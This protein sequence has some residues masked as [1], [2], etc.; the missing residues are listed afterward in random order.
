MTSKNTSQKNKFGTRIS[1]ADFNA[2]D[3]HWSKVIADKIL[4]IFPGEDMYTCAAGIS[5]SGVVHFG[6]F[7]DVMTVHAVI[8]ELEARG[9]K[10]KF[11]FSWDDFDRLRKVPAGVDASF[12]KYIGMPLSSIPDPLSEYPSYARRFEVEF[13]NAM[14]DLGIDLEFRVQTDEYK[15]GVYDDLII[16]AMQNRLEIADILLS[17][18]TE[19][20]KESKDLD[21]AKYRENFYPVSVYS[22]FSGKDNTKILNYDGKSTITYKCFDTGNEETIDFT[23]DHIVKLS[24]KV[25]WPMRWLF[26]GVVFEPGGKDHASPGG[27]YDTSSVIAKKIFDREAPIFVGYEFVGIRGLGAKMSGSKGNAISPAELLKIYEPELLKWLYLRRLPNQAFELAFDTEIY[28]QYDEYDREFKGNRIPFKQAV[29]F[30]QIMQWD[31]NK[32]IQFLKS[33][34]LNYDESSISIRMQKARAW[35]ETYNPSEMIVLRSDINKD[36]VATMSPESIAN[37]QKFVAK[38]K[39]GVTTTEE[40]EKVMYDIPKDTV[41]TDKENAPRQRAFFKDIYNLLISVDTGPRLSTFLW[42]LDRKKVLELLNM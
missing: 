32:L 5:P 33:V 25:D 42:A 28:R 11:I 38:L 8:K 12:E 35:L 15:K 17:F 30:G 14:K 10:T 6:N 21:E 1:S 3:A 36:Y 20:G 41:L 4:E 39:E 7:R 22:K 34:D 24:W 13:E 26:E 29:A 27:S 23:Q 16:K 40:L 9:K 19:K 18:M 37:V 31:E 2:P